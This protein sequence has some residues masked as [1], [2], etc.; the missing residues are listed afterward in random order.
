MI[1]KTMKIQLK[2][3]VF[4]E[5][6]LCVWLLILKNYC[7]WDLFIWKLTWNPYCTLCK[8]KRVNQ[9][10]WVSKCVKK[11]QIYSLHLCTFPMFVFFMGQK[12]NKT[13]QVLIRSSKWRE[14]WMVERFSQEPWVRNPQFLELLGL[15]QDQAVWHG[16]HTGLRPLKITPR[17][18]ESRPQSEASCLGGTMTQILTRLSSLVSSETLIWSK[19][20]S[21]SKHKFTRYQRCGITATTRMKLSSLD[22]S[23]HGSH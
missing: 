21:A 20:T 13:S 6:F 5:Q 7:L 17:E 16:A 14:I 18:Y 22:S 11:H 3:I 9:C 15:G 1:K 4:K 12:V 19:V 2:S 8:Y 10:I 23:E